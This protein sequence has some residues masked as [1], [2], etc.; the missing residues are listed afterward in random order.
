MLL[1]VVLG[2][3]ERRLVIVVV[4]ILVLVHE[5]RLD[6][7]DAF[8]GWVFLRQ[9]YGHRQNAPVIGGVDVVLI[10]ARRQHYGPR[11]RAVGELGV[12]VGL[13][14]LGALGLDREP[15]VV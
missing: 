8:L 6:D 11:E 9:P 2:H 15:A 1:L 5:D 13:A 10:G 12:P 3:V 4:V 14:G 7:L